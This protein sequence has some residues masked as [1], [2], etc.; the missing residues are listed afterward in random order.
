MLCFAFAAF[1]VTAAIHLWRMLGREIAREWPQTL[2]GV[3]D[4]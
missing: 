3:G 4:D 1:Y 2:M